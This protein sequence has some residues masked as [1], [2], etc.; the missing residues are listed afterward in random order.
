MYVDNI[1]DSL[2]GIKTYQ[3]KTMR[4]GFFMVISHMFIKK[5]HATIQKATLEGFILQMDS[6][7]MLTKIGFLLNHNHKRG[8][9]KARTIYVQMF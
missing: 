7:Y 4:T 8:K 9:L 1:T 3:G 6:L 2:Q 5:S